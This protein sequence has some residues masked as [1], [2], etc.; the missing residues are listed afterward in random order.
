MGHVMPGGLLHGLLVRA[1]HDY[2]FGVGWGGQG[3]A[4]VGPALPHHTPPT[5]PRPSPRSVRCSVGTGSSMP[6]LMAA[7]SAMD[8]RELRGS[9][10]WGEG[11]AGTPLADSAGGSLTEQR[12][13][14]APS[15]EVG[16]HQQKCPVSVASAVHRDTRQHALLQVCPLPS[17][18]A[19]GRGLHP[20]T[21]PLASV[22]PGSVSCRLWK[23][24]SSLAG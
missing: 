22:G 10:A 17:G 6:E 16:I 14:A 23:L 13:P 21:L 12:P 7:R 9:G 20:P 8:L 3:E 2:V 11:R 1:A 15:P 5:S 18:A 24:H 19:E 4:G